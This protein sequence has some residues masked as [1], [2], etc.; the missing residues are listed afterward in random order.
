MGL[1]QAREDKEQAQDL[2]DSKHWDPLYK[3]IAMGVADFELTLSKDKDTTELF[4]AQGAAQALRAL[5]NSI[6]GTAEGIMDG[7]TGIT[8]EAMEEMYERRQDELKQS[9]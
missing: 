5:V 6:M 4:R 9:S 3:R 1:E 8:I 7:K 2:L